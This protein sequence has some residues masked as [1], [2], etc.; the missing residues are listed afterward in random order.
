M[1]ETNSTSSVNSTIPSVWHISSDFFCIKMFY[2]VID[3]NCKRVKM[4]GIIQAPPEM[5]CRGKCVSF[6]VTNFCTRMDK[7]KI[8]CKRTEISLMKINTIFCEIEKTIFELWIQVFCNKSFDDF[9]LSFCRWSD[10]EIF[11]PLCCQY[12]I[13]M[14][15]IFSLFFLKNR[16]KKSPSMLDMR[17][18]PLT[19]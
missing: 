1:A 5:M 19:E 12:R 11:L 3:C 10:D 9:S 13:L 8:L 18:E 17:P 15:T 7:E 2:P 4:I 16:S 6:D 14:N